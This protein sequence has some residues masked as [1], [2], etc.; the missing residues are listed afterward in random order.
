MS[1]NGSVLMSV[2]DN[3]DG[4]S[5][6]ALRVSGF[7]GYYRQ[8]AVQ[9]CREAVSQTADSLRKLLFPVPT[10]S[11][12]ARSMPTLGISP[13]SGGN[14]PVTCRS[15]ENRVEGLLADQVNSHY[16]P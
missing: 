8:T 13:D 4:A 2:E 1:K 12:L 16:R 7:K 15:A 9:P 10:H 6:A 14:V 3:V 5:M 11:T